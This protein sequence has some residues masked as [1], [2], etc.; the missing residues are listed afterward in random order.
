MRCLRALRILI[1]TPESLFLMLC[2]RAQETLTHV[3]TV[4]VDEIHSVC[5][6][7]RGSHL[8]LSLERLEALRTARAGAVG[9]GPLQRIGL[10]ATQRPLDEVARLLGGYQSH[11]RGDAQPRPVQIVDA[12]QT[13]TFEIRVEVP[14]ENMA[15][16][17][18]PAELSAPER[19]HPEHLAENSSPPSGAHSCTSLH[20]DLRQ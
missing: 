10:S 11:L 16:L 2:S 6:T 9:V 1:T 14:V 18:R 19:R 5:S 15:E 4:I 7:K 20:D 3:D 8:A 13:K 17:G 12:G